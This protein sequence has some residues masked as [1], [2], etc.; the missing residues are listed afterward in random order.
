[1][2][3]AVLRVPIPYLYTA[4]TPEGVVAQG[5][6]MTAG[7]DANPV[8]LAGPPVSLADQKA[9]IT[10]LEVANQPANKATASGRVALKAAIKVAAFDRRRIRNWAEEIIQAHPEDAAAVLAAL[11][12]TPKP[13]AVRVVPDFR[14]GRGATAGSADAR[15]KGRHKGVIQHRASADNG[16]SFPVEGVTNEARYTYMGL[17]VGVMYLF[18]YRV[19]TKGL[20]GDWSPSVTYL[21]T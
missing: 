6:A 8:L 19:V 4:K 5:H 13:R 11:G 9:H 17:T 20:P 1:M 21:V 14:V 2:T 7:Q 15:V 3:T 10:A 18:Q 12:M 16:H